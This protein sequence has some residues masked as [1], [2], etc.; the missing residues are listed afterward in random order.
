MRGPGVVDGLVFERR[1]GGEP[2]S[3]HCALVQ[4]RFSPFHLCQEIRRV[5]S[6]GRGEENQTPQRLISPGFSCP[7]RIPV[8]TLHS[9]LLASDSLSLRFRQASQAAWFRK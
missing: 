7:I 4:T 9:R 2:R 8:A 5:F 6:F 1:V 3:R